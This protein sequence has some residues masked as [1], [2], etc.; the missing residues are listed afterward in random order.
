MVDYL[1]AASH[2]G[3]F[4]GGVS[5]TVAL[6]AIWLEWRKHADAKIKQA[7][8]EDVEANRYRENL[9]TEREKIENH[10]RNA[11]IQVSTRLELEI[12]SWAH[13]AFS[14]MM[15]SRS[16]LYLKGLSLEHNDQRSKNFAMSDVSASG[17][18]LAV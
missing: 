15:N 18:K 3:S 11:E 6:I 1:L 7:Q 12:I 10:R 2:I 9:E 17:S 5:A 4:I 14:E 16:E 8:D 13:N